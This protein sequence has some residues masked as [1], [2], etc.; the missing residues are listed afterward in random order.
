[1]KI[2]VIKKGER[3]AK[4]SVTNEPQSKREAAREIVSN[5]SNWVNDLQ[6]RKRAEARIGF[7]SLFRKGPQTT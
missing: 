1:M 5:V 3:E 2:K 4:T 6:D 7:E